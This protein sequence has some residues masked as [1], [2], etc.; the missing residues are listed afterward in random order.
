M[1]QQGYLTGNLCSPSRKGKNDPKDNSEIIWAA[2]PTVNQVDKPVFSSA[3]EDGDTSLVLVGQDDGLASASRARPLLAQGP[4]GRAPHRTEGAGSPW[5][6]ERVGL[7]QPPW[8]WSAE[9]LAR[10]DYSQA[11]RPNEQTQGP[12]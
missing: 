8:V 12:I 11:L 9:R 2:I 3:S 6:A 10:E 1:G 7:L 5:R 4:G